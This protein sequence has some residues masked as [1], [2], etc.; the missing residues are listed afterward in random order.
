MIL[1]YALR[2]TFVS[3]TQL[4]RFSKTFLKQ[5]ISL[6]ERTVGEPY[7]MYFQFYSERPYKIRIVKSNSKGAAL[8]FIPSNT[9]EYFYQT[10]NLEIEAAIF[11]SRK[12]S[13]DELS[14]KI[15]ESVLNCVPNHPCF[16]VKARNS[17]FESLEFVT[18]GKEW[19]EVNGEGTVTTKNIVANK[20]AYPSLTKMKASTLD[21][22]WS[23]KE[24]KR[25]AQEL[26]EW[27]FWPAFEAQRISENTWRILSWRRLLYIS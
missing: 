27:E 5:Y 12:L 15:L 10:T 13:E 24:A 11:P 8:I 22:S 17:T 4:I 2:N 25:E 1:D 20:V 3:E 18:I 16:V 7:R 23:V 9:S 19:I 26:L 14:K 21:K 6:V